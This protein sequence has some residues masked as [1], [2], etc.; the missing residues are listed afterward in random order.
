MPMAS[1]NG[2]AIAPVAG[3][4]VSSGTRSCVAEAMTRSSA[5][6][7]I[8]GVCH[9]FLPERCLTP[10]G[11]RM[12]RSIHLVLGAVVGLSLVGCAKKE[13]ATSAVTVTITSPAEGDTVG[14]TAVHVALGATGIEI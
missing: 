9:R 13:A 12:I 10:K 5:A 14:G 2:S 6:A 1:L 11:G 8:S 3:P 7:I 4:R